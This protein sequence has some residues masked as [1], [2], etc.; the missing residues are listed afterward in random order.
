[1]TTGI[2]EQAELIEVYHSL[3]FLKKYCNHQLSCAHCVLFTSKKCIFL[4]EAIKD[5]ELRDEYI[6]EVKEHVLEE[7]GLDS[8]E[9]EL[10]RK[11]AVFNI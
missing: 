4:P 1:M 9:L 3:C 2:D 5:L 8:L 10:D 7:T 6:E 11:G